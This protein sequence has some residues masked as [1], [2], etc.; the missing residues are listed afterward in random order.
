M[1][2][3][4]LK[5]CDQRVKFDMKVNETREILVTFNSGLMKESNVARS[6]AGKVKAYSLGKLQGTMSLRANMIYPTVEIS[7]CELNIITNLLPRACSFAIKNCGEMNSTFGLNFKESSTIFTK[8]QEQRQENL[9]NIVQCLMKQKCNLR[10]TFFMS[11]S[12]EQLIEATLNAGDESSSDVS[13]SIPID[14]KKKLKTS[15]KAGN[16]TTLNINELLSTTSGN[17]VTLSDIQKYFRH[18]TRASSKTLCNHGENVKEITENL[19]P[20]MDKDKSSA[21]NIFQL[22]QIKGTLKPQ[23]SRTIS[24]YFP[25]SDE[26]EFLSV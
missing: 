11:D 23:E 26:S 4:E 16:A 3:E 25:G 2:T 7:C 24:V 14:D 20:S 12:H 8:I 21:G 18:L 15:R 13:K 6:F 5:K 1:L 17:E 19:K 22:S 10:K 9:L